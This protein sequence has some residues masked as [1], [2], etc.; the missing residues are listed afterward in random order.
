MRDGAIRCMWVRFKGL[1][2]SGFEGLREKDFRQNGLK[3][4]LSGF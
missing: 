2:V 1:R 3:P 4:G